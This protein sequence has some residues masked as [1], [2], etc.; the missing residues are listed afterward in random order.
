[1]TEPGSLNHNAHS[2]LQ[3]FLNFLVKYFLLHKAQETVGLTSFLLFVSIFMCASVSVYVCKCTTHE[4]AA[5][6]VQRG[7]YREFLAAS[8]VLGTE[9]GPWEEL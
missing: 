9:P 6:R 2:T 8:W 5:H 4:L 7:C 3:T 1:M